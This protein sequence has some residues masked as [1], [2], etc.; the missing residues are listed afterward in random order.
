M[1]TDLSK[2]FID[3]AKELNIPE[4]VIQD[5]LKILN[6]NFFF[7]LQ[8]IKRIDNETW[9]KLNLPLNLYFI[10]QD[11]IK[12]YENN[13]ITI[14]NPQTNIQTQTENIQ[15]TQ[16]QKPSVQLQSTIVSNLKS[17]N[18][19]QQELE[20]IVEA[21][22]I[23]AKVQSEITSTLKI[24][25]TIIENI[26]KSPLDESLR[27]INIAS[28]SF[29]SRISPYKSTLRLLS[30]SGFEYKETS[31]GKFWIFEGKYEILKEVM[32][33]FALILKKK[34]IVKSDFNPYSTYISSV[35]TESTSNH[36]NTKEISKGIPEW[37]KLLR[38]L[39]ETRQ[40]IIENSKECN[41]NIQIFNTNTK[42]NQ[43]VNKEMTIFE[44]NPSEI[45]EYDFLLYAKNIL[46]ES[47]DDKF[48]IRSRIEF[49]RLSEEK[50]YTY[51]VIKLKFKN[52]F[53]LQACFAFQEKI[54][55]I[56]DLLYEHLD[57]NLFGDNIKEMTILSAYPNKKYTNLS[58][59]I[60]EEGLYP[61]VLLY[62]NLNFKDG[63]LKEIFNKNSIEKYGDEGL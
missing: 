28:K 62:V 22:M 41:R 39:K 11:K 16:S 33:T 46:K 29:L 4:N 50:V 55:S 38:Q 31:D 20:N 47:R 53:I 27:K 35:S 26:V 9:T 32:N 6:S 58:K 25:F 48:K 44:M 24:L 23:E 1:N 61:N 56:Y 57:L 54:K 36:S 15:S 45:E 8:D 12:L 17:T 18:S 37:D 60:Y 49:E 7:R 43:S 59:S 13:S 63:I 14:S 3:I 10:L 42:S 51:S 2:V 52:E 30:L 5:P 19:I 34:N 40:K 21:I